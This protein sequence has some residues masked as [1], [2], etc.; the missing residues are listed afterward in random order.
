MT[1][2]SSTT[3]SSLW[4][5]VLAGYSNA[6]RLKYVRS[7]LR[8]HEWM[9][10]RPSSSSFP[11]PLPPRIV[12]NLLAE[13]LFVLYN[14]GCGKAEAACTLYGICMLCPELKHHLHLS[15]AVFRGY[16]S[17]LPSNPHPPMPWTVCTAL[18]MWLASNGKFPLA[19]GVILSF[20]CYL[21]IG[22][23]IK[24][25][26]DDIA[27]AGDP[28]LGY[29]SSSSDRVHINIR[30]AKTGILQGVEVRDPQ[31]KH[32]VR[33]WC[34]SCPGPKLFPFSESTYRKWFTRGCEAL[35]VAHYTPHSLR[36]GGATRDFLADVKI[37]D[38]T[39][40]GRWRNIKTT[41]HY[42]QMG[43]QLMLL[44]KVPGRV[45]DI[46]KAVSRALVPALVIASVVSSPS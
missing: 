31:V 14:A 13:Y 37:A 3:V 10:D 17:L 35:C 20:D 4:D 39:V 28:R 16:S 6:T 18:A 34:D 23:M 40:R 25:L 29:L 44:H 46:G 15:R 42:I 32:L 30:A 27:F 1:S 26:K 5:L 45:A 33:V 7:V 38:I 2:S 9:N 43:P 8:F 22:E 21:R 41:T 36:H 11:F 12:D 19:V 24:L